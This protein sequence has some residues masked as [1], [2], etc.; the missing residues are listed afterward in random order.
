M[1]LKKLKWNLFY[2]NT[3]QIIYEIK[4]GFGGYRKEILLGIIS[5]NVNYEIKTYR[6]GMKFG[7]SRPGNG[8]EFLLIIFN[9]KNS[10]VEYHMSFMKRA[11][12]Y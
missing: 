2:F 12:E 1:K 5:N 11:C 9:Y 3:R 7:L 4:G 6:L 8:Y 10:G